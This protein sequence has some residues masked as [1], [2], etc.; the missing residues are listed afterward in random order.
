MTRLQFRILYREFLFRMVDREV[1]ATHAQGD[2]TKLLGRLASVL[3]IISIPFAIMALTSRDVHMGYEDV[4]IAAWSMEH[5]LIATTMLIVGLFA[6]LSWDSIFPDR[7]DVLVLAPLPVRANT[8]LLAKAAS[9]AVALG[10]AVVTFNAAP[11]LALP[12]VLA[13]PSSSPL[14]MM[15]SLG[16]YRALMAYWITMTAS[17]GFI[18]CCGLIVQGLSAQLPRRIFLRLSAFLQMAVFCLLVGVYF[19]QP[20]LASLKLLTVAE[21]QQL[22]RWLPTYWFLGLLQQLNG[23]LDGPARSTLETLANRA[24]IGLAVAVVGAGVTFLLAYLRTVR[25]IVEEP[26]IIPAYGHL[27]WL[28]GFGKLV[29]TAVVHFSIRSLLRSRPHRVIFSF[30]AGLGFA[31]L[32]LFLKTPVAQ[33]LSTSSTGDA[34]HQVTLPFLASSFL[35]LAVW[36]LGVRV[37]FAMP[38]ELRANW[39]FRITELRD[40]AI[41]QQASRKAL[42]TLSV[43]PVWSASAIVFLWMWPWRPA[44]EHLIVLALVGLAMLDLC[45]YGFDKIPFTCSYLP[46]KSNL[47]MTFALCLMGGL[48]ATYWCAEFERRAL[49]DQTKYA[50]IVVTLTFVS[51]AAWWRTRA[52]GRDGGAVRF[53]EEMS[54]VISGLGLHRDGILAIEPGR[55]QYPKK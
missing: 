43:M 34:M 20:S 10:A 50:W 12:L 14:D 49:S 11:G 1:L 2:A 51:V 47:H 33:K 27:A 44:V 26:D 9:L 19:L 4:L 5:A 55:E 21:N 45:L 24:W 40:A 15:F 31:I 13:P 41:Y 48:N 39:V 54:P 17:G 42:I 7:R 22:L 29:D 3:V 36:A 46:G 23:S 37:V 8:M 28:P 6:V 38:L 53:E 18:F 52:A 35:L 30:Y 32:I 25:K 16:I